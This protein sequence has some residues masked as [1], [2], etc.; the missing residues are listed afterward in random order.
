MSFARRSSLRAHTL[1]TS[2]VA[3]AFVPGNGLAEDNKEPQTLESL[4]VTMWPEYDRP[5]VLVMYRAQLGPET[6]LPAQISLPIPASV[7]AP[8]AVA[9]RAP[10]G[11]LLV[12]K[13]SQKV[14]G[15][16]ATVTVT[17]DS[18]QVQL[19]FYA[20][21]K[22]E[23]AGRSYRFHWPGGTRVKRFSYVIQEPPDATSFV[24]T[25]PP[26]TRAPGADGLAYNSA[27]L[28]AQGAKDELSIELSYR[29]TSPHLTA[30]MKNQSQT[31]RPR[32]GSGG[33]QPVSSDGSGANWVLICLA[34]F[35]A[36]AIGILVARAKREPEESDESQPPDRES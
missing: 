8:H 5:G 27:D 33:G 4:E 14:S 19:E 23:Q 21:L 26:S 30:D 7:G 36:F 35:V 12:A 17:A 29:K 15:D 18:P 2:L 22:T 24:I 1:I 32:G 28:G 20:K 11:V 16:W 3:L 6:R 9:T 25:P 13:Y 31:H 34:L 10:E